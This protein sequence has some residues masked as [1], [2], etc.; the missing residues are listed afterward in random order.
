[1][2]LARC[3]GTPVIP[4][5]G[6]WRQENS[7]RLEASP[8]YIVSSRAAWTADLPWGFSLVVTYMVS[9]WQPMPPNRGLTVPVAS[10]FSCGISCAGDLPSVLTS[11]PGGEAGP[12]GSPAVGQHLHPVGCRSIRSA[13]CPGPPNFP[14]V[15]LGWQGGAESGGQG[16]HSCRP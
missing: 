4:G 8:V 7:C 16:W 12:P 5:V 3:G 14:S 15:W 10:P 1:M 13:L 9:Q 11:F 6:R 2:G